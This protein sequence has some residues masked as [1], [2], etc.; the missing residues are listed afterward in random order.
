MIL[1]HFIYLKFSNKTKPWWSICWKKPNETLEPPLFRYQIKDPRR[2]HTLIIDLQLSNTKNIKLRTKVDFVTWKKN[3]VIAF[4]FTFIIH[5]Q[6]PL[7]NQYRQNRNVDNI[8]TTLSVHNHCYFFPDVN[9]RLLIIKISFIDHTVWSLSFLI[10]LSRIF[11]LFRWFASV[12]LYF[13]T[14][15]PC[16][17]IL[18]EKNTPFEQQEAINIF[19]LFCLC[20]DQFKFVQNDWL[21]GAPRSTLTLPFDW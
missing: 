15:F 21:I 12:G 13:L 3:S 7:L 18:R 10:A 17:C 2:I 8:D 1:L 4:F 20:W 16:T 6:C 19:V 14:Y 5:V 9:R 11:V